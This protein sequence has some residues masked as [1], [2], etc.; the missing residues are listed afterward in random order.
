MAT[1]NKNRQQQKIIWRWWDKHRYL[2]LIILRVNVVRECWWWWWGKVCGI[3][4]NDIIAI[5]Y[6]RSKCGRIVASSTV[7]LFIF[8]AMSNVFFFGVFCRLVGWFVWLACM[9]N[10]VP[11]MA[12]N[13]IW[14][15]DDLLGLAYSSTKL[16]S[17]VLQAFFLLSCQR[18]FMHERWS[19]ISR[20]GVVEQEK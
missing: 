1:K 9:L 10:V 15:K 5:F 8:F 12:L 4:T 19:N 2:I 6:G 17:S 14:S 7:A 13:I 3:T 20:L 18:W 16:S 11:K